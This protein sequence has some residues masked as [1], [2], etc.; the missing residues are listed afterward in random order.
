MPIATGMLLAAEQHPCYVP[1]DAR[2]WRNGSEPYK[3][4]PYKML[5]TCSFCLHVWA[6]VLP[7]H[8]MISQVQVARSLTCL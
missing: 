2:S 4:L 3:S 6:G 8:L 1:S 7:W 5:W